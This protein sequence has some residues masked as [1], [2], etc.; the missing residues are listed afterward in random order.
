M[1]TK[2]RLFASAMALLVMAGAALTP[3]TARASEEGRRNT[4]LGLGAL[5]GYLF[6]RGGSKVPAF[7]GLGATAY[8]YK[9]Y[10]DKVNERH[11]RERSARLY[12]Y[13]QSAYSDGYRDASYRRSYAH[14]SNYGRY[15]SSS[16]RHHGHRHSRRHR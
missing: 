12:R 15:V 6:T 10:Q 16:R 13:Y 14:R 3:A 1:Q 5:T 8:A 4:A 9:K 2:N 7:V 11:R